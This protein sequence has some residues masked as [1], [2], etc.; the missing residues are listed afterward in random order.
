MWE[1]NPLNDAWIQKSSLPGGVR[2]GCSGFV[3]DSIAYVGLGQNGTTYFNDLYAYNI[4]TDSWTSAGIF[5]GTQRVFPGNFSVG[6]S[7][8]LCAGGIS[9]INVNFNDCWKFGVSTGVNQIK[10]DETLTVTPNPCSD[11]FNIT[12]PKSF[13]FPATLKLLDANGKVVFSKELYSHKNIIYIDRKI[14]SGIYFGVCFDKLFRVS[15]FK[16]AI[17]KH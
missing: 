3:I 17:Q 13:S 14:S 5:P 8:F 12:L 4:N 15:N 11:F 9:G 1:Y 7:G 6:N 16:I 2:Y 10:T